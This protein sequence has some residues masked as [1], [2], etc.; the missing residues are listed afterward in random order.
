MF[1]PNEIVWRFEHEDEADNRYVIRAT[2]D[3]ERL[4]AHRT[5]TVT[6]LVEGWA[7]DEMGAWDDAGLLKV[8]VVH[9]PKLAGV[10]HASMAKVSRAFVYDKTTEDAAEAIDR[11]TE[12][13]LVAGLDTLTSNS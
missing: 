4:S 3:I 12:R 5:D 13:Q 9:P 1:A 8:I 6:A 10:Y 11:E 2:Q 7:D